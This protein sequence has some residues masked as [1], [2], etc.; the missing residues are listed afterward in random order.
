MAAYGR[1]LVVAVQDFEHSGI[2]TLTAPLADA[3]RLAN[4]LR[5]PDIGEYAVESV[6]VNPDRF[7]LVSRLSAFLSEV[8]DHEVALVHIATHGL[9]ARDGMF[10]LAAADTDPGSPD[11]GLDA[12]TLHRLIRECRSRRLVVILDCCYAARAFGGPLEPVEKYVGQV[13][14]RPDGG[15]GK[16]IIAAAASRE[17]AYENEGRSVFTGALVAG[18]EGGAADVDR[19]GF[20]TVDDLD[21]YLHKAM[22]NLAQDQTPRMLADVRGLR[23]RI[24]TSPLGPAK[25]NEVRYRENLDLA[26]K[27]RRILEDLGRRYLID[28][29]TDPEHVR[30]RVDWTVNFWRELQ[31]RNEY[32]YL[33]LLRWLQNEHKTK[34]EAVFADPLEDRLFEIQHV[35]EDSRDA[36]RDPRNRITGI[37]GSWQIC[38][39]SDAERIRQESGL[40]A[41]DLERLVDE[42]GIY[43]EEPASLPVLTPLLRATQVQQVIVSTG[44]R[45]VLDLLWAGDNALADILGVLG[46]DVQVADRP[47]IRLDEAAVAA[48]ARRRPG[49]LRTVWSALEP[50][51]AGDLRHLFLWQIAEHGRK[52]RRAGS[53]LMAALRKWG[54][55]EEDVRRLAYAIDAESTP[56]QRPAL[57]HLQSDLDLGRCYGSYT[58]VRNLPPDR[59]D[60]E[61]ERAAVWLTRR[62]EQAQEWLEEAGR[63]EKPELAWQLLHYAET[64]VP[65]LPGVAEAWRRFPPPAPEQVEVT[66]RDLSVEIRWTPAG[67]PSDDVTYRVV[68]KIS[69]KDDFRPVETEPGADAFS[70]IDNRPPVR[71]TVWYAVV[72]ERNGVSSAPRPAESVRVLP[73]VTGLNGRFEADRIILSWQLPPGAEAVM[74]RC[75]DRAEPWEVRGYSYTDTDVSAGPTYEYDV[76]ARYQEGT[77]APRRVTVST[78][79]AGEAVRRLDVGY[80]ATPGRLSVKFDHPDRGELMIAFSRSEPPAF[81]TTLRGQGLEE[82]GTMVGGTHIEMMMPNRPGWVYAV[83]VS[84]D[85]RTYGARTT[86]APIPSIGE[87]PTVLRRGTDIQVSWSWPVGLLEAEVSWT[88]TDGTD[89]RQA[90]TRGSYENRGGVWIPATGA[91]TTVRVFPIGVWAGERKRGAAAD[92]QVAARPFVRYTLDRTP[93]GG[94]DIGLV[95][96]TKVRIP[97]L[98]VVTATDRQPLHGDDGLVRERLSD[99]VLDGETPYRL[100]VGPPAA[101]VRWVRC[102]APES[103]VE[104]IDPPIGRQRQWGERR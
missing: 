31:V 68:R 54:L 66:V 86:Y 19:D 93:D 20:V 72:A 14:G 9:V 3:E 16:V 91:A 29:P 21:R 46:D 25:D 4:V 1:A 75:G 24:A 59:R 34:Y 35:V 8:T 51:T 97:R 37:A 85:W 30:E 81:G 95:S 63:E 60:K 88:A 77:S 32:E 96:P 71:Q 101:T 70:A 38:R 92:A 43:L 98:L 69:A 18:L 62:V 44:A 12:D 67:P 58:Y 15:G 104:L 45:H 79:R 94:I 90:V 33:A 7:A 57:E 28:N 102:F 50:L 53:D 64:W 80:A 74:I 61:L 47:E 100:T 39:R 23:F 89:G 42:L 76:L 41:E 27:D 2:P 22:Q 48:A 26:V 6:L 87:P 73:P 83:T 55:V 11:T 13:L 17:T 84:G 36:S 10:Y 65:D 99:V 5:R 78:T 52:T 103:D 49:E 56:K 82:A 40:T